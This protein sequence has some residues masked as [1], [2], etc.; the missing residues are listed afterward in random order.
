[1]HAFLDRYHYHRLHLGFTL[2]RPPLPHA[3]RDRTDCRIFMENSASHA[4]LK[5]VMRQ[6]PGELL[7]G[8]LAPLIDI[9]Y[10]RRA[11]AAYGV[12]NRL[13]TEIGR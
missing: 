10:L 6:Q 7:S 2:M 3:A 4:D 9:E 11:I 13:E 5:A 12:P 8:K 1:M